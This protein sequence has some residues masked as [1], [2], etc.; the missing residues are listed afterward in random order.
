MDQDPGYLY[1]RRGEASSITSSVRSKLGKIQ[2]DNM[3]LVAM[4]LKKAAFV[5]KVNKL[6]TAK[7]AIDQKYQMEVE[8]LDKKIEMENL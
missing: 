3:R 6:K 2:I 1:S 5:Q 7:A 4:E 8:K